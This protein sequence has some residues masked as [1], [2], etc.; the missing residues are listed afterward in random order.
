MNGLHELH[1]VHAGHG[2]VGDHGVHAGELVE[3]FLAGA[4]D[5]RLL[6]ARAEESPQAGEHPGIVVDYEDPRHRSTP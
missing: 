1:A 2:E 6:A 3:R 4:R 5:H